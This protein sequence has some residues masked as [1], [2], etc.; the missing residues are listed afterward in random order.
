MSG[1]G[2]ESSFGEKSVFISYLLLRNGSHREAA[3]YVPS[4]R[5]YS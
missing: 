3:G 1:P 4:G 2:T 5:D